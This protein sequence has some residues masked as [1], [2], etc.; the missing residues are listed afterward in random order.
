ML[1]DLARNAALPDKTDLPAWQNKKSRTALF[2]YVWL[3]KRDAAA[4]G[5]T[6]LSALRQL[7]PVI[8]LAEL[9]AELNRIAA[10][11]SNVEYEVHLPPDMRT[12]TIGP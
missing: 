1:L 10:S 5:S 6:L 12:L 8:Q 7:S 11:D 9:D 4:E 2:R 3:K